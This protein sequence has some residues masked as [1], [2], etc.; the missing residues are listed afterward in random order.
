MAHWRAQGPRSC[1]DT[2]LNMPQ[3]NRGAQYRALRACMPVSSRTLAVDGNG[4]LACYIA[5]IWPIVLLG[6]LIHLPMCWIQEATQRTR[7]HRDGDTRCEAAEPF[8][9]CAYLVAALML[10]LDVSAACTVYTLDDALRLLVEKSELM[11]CL[12]WL[13]T[14]HIVSLLQP[15]TPRDST[16]CESRLPEISRWANA[17]LE[18]WRAGNTRFP[19]RSSRCGLYGAQVSQP[20]LWISGARV[21]PVSPSAC[22]RNPRL[23]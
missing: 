4:T 16:I 13:R 22:D 18:P 10:E 19:C 14:P 5:R 11:A 7:G 21:L 6:E 8:S 15:T 3:M 17:G 23:T 20:G 12:S 2:C 1:C 9:A